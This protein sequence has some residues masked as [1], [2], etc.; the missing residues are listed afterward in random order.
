MVCSERSV[1]VG[2][3]AAGARQSSVRKHGVETAVR[4]GV[5]FR[6]YRSRFQHT[7]VEHQVSAKSG[8]STT[9]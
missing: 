9:V 3:E 7:V 2:L 4:I 5:D 1:S 6:F 8:A